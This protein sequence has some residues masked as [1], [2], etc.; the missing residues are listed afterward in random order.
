M[1]LSYSET[2]LANKLMTPPCIACIVCG[3]IP[4]KCYGSCSPFWLQEQS[5]V[6]LIH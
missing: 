1:R 6:E 3:D 4:K 2:N 5:N